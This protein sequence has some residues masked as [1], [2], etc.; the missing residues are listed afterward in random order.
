MSR[1]LLLLVAMATAV[2]AS[3]CATTALEAPGEQ[4]AAEPSALTQW[5]ARGRLALVAQGE[6]G[7]GSFAWDQR[8]ERTE[9]ALRGPL[10]AG[11]LR[12]VSDGETFE[13][14]DNSGRLLDGEAARSEVERRLGARLPLTEL[15]YW[16]L[17][18]PAPARTGS[19]PVQMATGSVPGFVQD[20]WVLS[21]EEFQAYA[22]WALPVR[23]TATTSGTRVRIVIDDW[24]LPAP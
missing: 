21:F 18:V 24:I 20:G 6:G 22:G 13:L 1:A 19:S 17:G 15:R 9:L 2:L 11:G 4:R 5:S 16:L 23:L 14:S 7:S 3:G 10:G 8:S 12:L